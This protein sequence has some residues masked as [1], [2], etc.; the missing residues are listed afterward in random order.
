MVVMCE[1]VA[2]VMSIV[3]RDRRWWWGDFL[4]NLKNAAPDG[5]ESQAGYTTQVD[6][7]LKEHSSST[8]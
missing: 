1:S 8:A 7:P 6:V 5:P 3:G 2:V 4:R